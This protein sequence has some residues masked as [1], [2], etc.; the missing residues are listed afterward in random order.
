WAC[1]PRRSGAGCRS[2]QPRP[3]RRTRASRE[4]RYQP[5]RSYESSWVYSL[6]RLA[7]SLGRRREP[8]RA[9][10]R[11]LERRSER[12]SAVERDV[13]V[14]AATPPRGRLQHLG[15]LRDESLALLDPH[16]LRGP[17]DE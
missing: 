8:C 11:L 9:V 13:S 16:A 5:C 14:L 6:P 10:C 4:E 15:G 17:A 3:A 2:D 12:A 7:S 1:R